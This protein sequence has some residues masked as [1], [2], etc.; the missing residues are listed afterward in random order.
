M[1]ARELKNFY[2]KNKAKD[3][4]DRMMSTGDAIHLATAIIHDATEFHTRDKNSKGGNV[5][6]LG[7]PEQSP[8]GKLCGI[9][10]LK[11]ISPIAVQGNLD[12]GDKK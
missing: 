2:F 6:L 3:G 9:Y 1:L 8:G 12:L 11:I 4:E 10:D 7:L 5:K